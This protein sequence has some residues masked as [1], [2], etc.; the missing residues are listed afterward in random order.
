MKRNY[1][2]D[3][4]RTV[5]TFLVILLHA[6][7]DYVT[8]GLNNKTFDLSFWIGNLVDSFS[9]ICVPLFVLI[10]GMFL[11]GRNESFKQSYTKRASRILIPLISWSLIYLFYR[12]TLNYIDNNTFDLL[13]LAKSII[14]GMPFYHLWYLYMLIGLY[15]FVPILNNNISKISRKNLWRLSFL[16]LIFG[17][18]NTGYNLILGNALIFF[19]WFLNYLGYFIIGYLI[20]GAKKRK[21]S[22]KLIILYI[23]SCILI[24]I[25]S[26]YTAKYFGSLY[27]Y[28]YLSPF[29]IIAS[30]SI[31]TLFH[32]VNL[33][34]NILS[35][36]SH[37]TLG[38]YLVHA[39]VLDI[40]CLIFIKFN[41]NFLD[42]P[43]IGIPV[44]FAI[45]LFLS[46]IMA[47]ILNKNKYLK[48]II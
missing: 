41:I 29:V 36:I 2:I 37:L 11:I 6:S 20:K 1:T 3:T 24:S 47:Y 13:T 7:T 21:S 34:E 45:T 38:I 9:R 19:L 25:L 33:K 15:L 10:S 23:T 14:I 31:Y 44:K 42:N 22:S 35:K 28:E 32:Q 48:K 43:I 46:L 5:A 12:G 8:R 18:L 26:F 30:L 39:G 40:L 17:M 16:L 27:F 4:L